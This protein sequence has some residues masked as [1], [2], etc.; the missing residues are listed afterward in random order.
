MTPF[1]LIIAGGRNYTPNP[2]ES[3]DLDLVSDL[4]GEVVCGKAT[5]VDTW[6]EQW[7]KR[8]GIAVKYFPADWAAKGKLAGF[9]R[10][11][12]MAAYADALAVFNGGR[13]TADMVQRAMFHG[14]TIWDHRSKVKTECRVVNRHNEEFDIY[15]G[16]GSKWGNPYVEG[17]DG[18]RKTVIQKYQLWI[19]RQPE[20]LAALPELKGKVLGCS[21]APKPCHGD[22]LVEMVRLLPEKKDTMFD[23]L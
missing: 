12:Q 15:I 21:C 19:M 7:A 1:K 3:D 17:T 22:V 8:H 23:D 18:S 13:G 20:L 4:V 2:A 9:F 11:E 16:R 6:G 14:L 10:N 5:G